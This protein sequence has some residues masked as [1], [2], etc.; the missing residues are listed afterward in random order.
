MRL[1]DARGFVGRW[2]RSP[3][4][5]V[6]SSQVNGSFVV[7][8]AFEGLPIVN[9]AS[10]RSI[11]HAI[12]DRKVVLIPVGDEEKL[13]ARFLNPIISRSFRRSN[14]SGFAFQIDPAQRAAFAVRSPYGSQDDHIDARS[15]HFSKPDDLSAGAN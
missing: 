10:Q 13:A 14:T 11:R 1:G 7:A 12:A 6:N 5:Q 4:F 3:G 15:N 8:V 2:S 9:A